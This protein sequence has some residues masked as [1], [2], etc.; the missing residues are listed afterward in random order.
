MRIALG[1]LVRNV[2]VRTTSGSR[3]FDIN[4]STR[5]RAYHGPTRLALAGL[6]LILALAILWNAG[7]ALMGYRDVLALR[8]EIDRVRQQDQGLVAEALQ[9]GIDLSEAALRHLPTEVALANQLLEKRLFSWTKFL[10]GLEQALPPRLALNSVRLDIGGTT[11]RLSGTAMGLEDITAFTV[12]LQDH[13][14]FKDPVLAQH[15]VGT[16]GLVE[17]DVTLQY[18]QERT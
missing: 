1:A 12:G 15:R 2:A 3:Y 8:A 16:N 5:S 13:P 10:T 11:V 9:E 7:L 4:L 18:R 17:F 6:C 14:L